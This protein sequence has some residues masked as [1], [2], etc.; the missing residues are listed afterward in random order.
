MVGWPFGLLVSGPGN[1]FPQGAV[2]LVTN[3]GGKGEAQAQGH[4]E[5]GVGRMCGKTSREGE[6]GKRWFRNRRWDLILTS[7][8]PSPPIRLPQIWPGTFSFASPS[9]ALR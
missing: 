2:L 8:T 7:W 1:H 4:M 6:K 5:L 9:A 3:P